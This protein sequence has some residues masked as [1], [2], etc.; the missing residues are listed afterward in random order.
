MN[1]LKEPLARMANRE[2]TRGAFLEGRFKSVAI[3]DDEA[4]LATCAYIDLN[5]VAAGIAAVP[6]ESEHTS[7]PHRLEHVETGRAG[8]RRCGRARPA[9]WRRSR[10]RRAWRRGTGSARS[11]IAGGWTRPARG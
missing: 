1:C 4:L 6:E 10:R 7:I 3:L 2:G 8:A 9:A 5:P 11:R